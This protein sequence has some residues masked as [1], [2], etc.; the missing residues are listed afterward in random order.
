MIRAP[1]RSVKTA[2]QIR[3]AAD[4]DTCPHMMA[5]QPQGQQSLAERCV[6]SPAGTYPTDSKERRKEL[7]K[8][9]KQ[10]GREIAV[11]KKKRS[12]DNVKDDCGDVLDGLDEDTKH[13]IGFDLQVDEIYELNCHEFA[14]DSFDHPRWFVGAEAGDIK[15]D[16]HNTLYFD[17]VHALIAY[18]NR[19]AIAA[20]CLRDCWR[21]SAHIT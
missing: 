4:T 7:E 5:D 13:Y 10:E 2:T 19:L 15:R 17:N 16:L 21:H 14:E 6:S 12:Y 20:G 18:Q 1:V 9:A 8:K 3:D 11:R